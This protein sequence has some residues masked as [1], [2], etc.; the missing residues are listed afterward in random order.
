MEVE[1]RV[2]GVRFFAQRT[3]VALAAAFFGAVVKERC[4]KDIKRGLRQPK[5]NFTRGHL[6]ISNP[7]RNHR[8]QSSTPH[9][10]KQ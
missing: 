4:F 9:L 5:P 6:N 2:R 3:R 8:S 1:C 7:K 10:F